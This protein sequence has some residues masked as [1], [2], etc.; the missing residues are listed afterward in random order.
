[1]KFLKKLILSS[2]FVLSGCAIDP[3]TLLPEE[4][5][6]VISPAVMADCEPYKED[7]RKGAPF[8]EVL[9]IHGENAK[10]YAKC[11]GLNN[12]KKIIIEEFLLNERSKQTD[13]KPE[14]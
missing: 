1:M 7:L 11:K 5:K 8:E 3:P 6:V 9:I 13:S 4:Q 12:S 2:I 10:I 14:D